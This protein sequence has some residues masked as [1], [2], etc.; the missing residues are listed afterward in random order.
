MSRGRGR[1]SEVSGRSWNFWADL[2]RGCLFSD[3]FGWSVCLC[4]PTGPG[5]DRAIF[6]VRRRSAEPGG[7]FFHGG[8]LCKKSRVLG[9]PVGKEVSKCGGGF[10]PG[11]RSFKNWVR[12][13]SV[14]EIRAQNRG[15]PSSPEGELSENRR[16]SSSRSG[17]RSRN[18]EAVSS[19]EEGHSKIGC[20]LLPWK[21]FVPKT[22][23][24]L[25]P[26]WKFSP[27]LSENRATAVS[28]RRRRPGARRARCKW[29]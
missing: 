13:S 21:K 28:P 10:F 17:K 26:W 15:W 1:G 3:A 27:A 6:P 4:R 5:S 22:G 2:W 23:G 12:P 20:D 18:A 25:L 19:R 9:F 24:R 16:F 14:E 7:V 29:R 11:R 8:R